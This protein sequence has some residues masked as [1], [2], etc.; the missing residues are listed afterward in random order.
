MNKEKVK[1]II[2]FSF[3]KY[4]QNKWFIIFNV[5]SLL[6]MIVSFNYKSF[7][8]FLNIEGKKEKYK[9]EV[10]DTESLLYEEFAEFYKDDEKYEIE[11]IDANNYTNEN[12][13][14]DLMILEVTKDEAEIFKFKLVSKEGIKSNVYEKIVSN[15]KTIRNKQFVSKYGVSEDRLKLFQSD[16]SIERVMLSVDAKDS[17]IKNLVNLFASALTYL[18][19]VIVFTRIANEV[20]QEKSS[21]SS[22]YILT[23]VTGKDYLFAKVFSN[24]AIFVIQI[25]LMVSYLAISTSILSIFKAQVTD[26]SL[27]DALKIDGFSKDIVTYLLT[28][29]FYNIITLILMSII[30]AT[31]AA[32]TTSASEAGNT[33]SILVF[34]MAAMYIGTVAL[35][36]PYTKANVFIYILS[37][38]PVFSGF[39]VPAMMVVGQA[40]WW[41][42]VISIIMLFLIIPKTFNYCATAFKNG[43]LD[44]TK[45]KKKKQLWE[46]GI[47]NS[48]NGIMNKRTF[49]QLGSV[50]GISIIIYIGSQ[51][52]IPL[53]ISMV[54]E[55]FFAF[56]SKADQFLLLQMLSQVSCLGLAYLFVRA[57]LKQENKESKQTLAFSKVQIIV[58]VLAF[59]VLLQLGLGILYSYIGLDYS[60][61]NQ[62]QSDLAINQLA[63]LHTK[64]LLVLAIG[65]TP[66]IMEELFF[67]KGLIDLTKKYG[68]TFALLISA[69]LFGLVHMNL[70]QGLFA[71]VIGLFMGAVY[72]YTKDIKLTML[73]HFANNGFEALL[74]VLPI[75]KMELIAGKLESVPT[76][77]GWIMLSIPIIIV[78]YGAILLIKFLV[79][80]ENRDRIKPYLNKKI[81]LEQFGKKHIYMFYDYIFVVS[82]ILLIVL[83]IVQEKMYRAM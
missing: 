80:K 39:F 35:I 26:I 75:E 31:M 38:L 59:V 68:K 71:F 7:T 50:I 16:L 15:L 74:L 8:S 83:S 14:D 58:I 51:T 2:K 48:I 53:L 57:Y 78:L 56:L 73:I 21:K 27:T 40:T 64:I 63:P 5:L 76:I 41:Q 79:K 23:T 62:L 13:K 77:L 43:L 36:D 70:S 6:T 69:L 47:D 17:E 20:S 60:I 66:A 33:V 61:T 30:Q 29:I 45:M 65:L 10:V 3:F 55:T 42:F 67:R 81:N 18:I 52:I 22:E 28:V 44:Y 25:V 9:I 72:L 19:S 46:V 32:K 82:M 4:F 49:K 11:K 34:I 1:E 37:V 12:I 54:L 24:I